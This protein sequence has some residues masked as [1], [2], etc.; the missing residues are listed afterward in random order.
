MSNFGQVTV[1]DVEAAVSVLKDAA[2]KA[3][4]GPIPDY[5]GMQ[6]LRR[7]AET[8]EAL[9]PRS[10]PVSLARIKPTRDWTTA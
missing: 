4:S 6:S 5:E 9:L 10:Q 8:L 2:D 3:L 7:V 1:G